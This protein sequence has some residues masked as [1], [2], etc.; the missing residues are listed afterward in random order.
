MYRKYL[1]LFVVVLVLSIPGFVSC[2]EWIT[3]NQVTVVWDPVTKFDNGQPIPAD[4]IIEYIVYLV[5]SSDIEKVDPVAIWTADST[6]YTITL[7]VEGRWFVGLQTL[8]KDSSGTILSRSIVGWSDDPLI[9]S[10]G[11]VFG[12]CYYLA[13]APISNLRPSILK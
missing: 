1:S 11:R 9:V 5:R 4:D 10:E 7:G 12:L 8:R 6:E 13:P 3:A 2:Q